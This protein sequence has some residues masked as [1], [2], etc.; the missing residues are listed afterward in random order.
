M[1][2]FKYDFKDYRVVKASQLLSRNKGVFQEIGPAMFLKADREVLCL[3]SIDIHL[4]YSNL[5]EYP[6]KLQCVRFPLNQNFDVY[7]RYRRKKELMK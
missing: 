4:N 3:E 7:L 1:V 6:C 5:N 2:F